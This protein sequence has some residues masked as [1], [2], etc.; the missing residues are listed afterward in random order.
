MIDVERQTVDSDGDAACRY[1]ALRVIEQDFR[2]L[3]SPAGRRADHESAQAFLAG[4][5]IFYRWCEIANVSAAVTEPLVAV[6]CAWPAACAVTTP[7]DV[8]LA[9]A[10]AVDCHASSGSGI[11]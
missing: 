3:T 8:T 4:S 7:A 6:I 9:I 1:L 11:G 2:D 5:P 10:G